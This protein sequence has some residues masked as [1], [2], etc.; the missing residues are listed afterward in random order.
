MIKQMAARFPY[1]DIHR[2]G[3]FGTSGGGYGASHAIL[4]FPEFYKVGVSTSGDHDARL[5]KAWWN[6]AVSG[7]SDAGRL[8]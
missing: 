3:V 1:M 5:D 6:E 7:I 2:V 4:V 8:H